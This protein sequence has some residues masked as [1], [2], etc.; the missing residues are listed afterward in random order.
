MT[1]TGIDGNISYAH[2]F[3][4][5]SRL[6]LSTVV[7]WL[8]SR[9]E[10]AVLNDPSHYKRLDRVVGD[11][12][13]RALANVSFETERFDISLTGQYIGKQTIGVWNLQNYEQDRAPTN[14]DAYPV[15]YYPDLF[16]ADIQVGVK[17]NEKFRLY[18]GVDNVTDQ[19]PPYGATGTGTGTAIFP[20]TG[21]Y[22]YAG[23]R[24][25]M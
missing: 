1:T 21:R 15:V 20:V 11:P 9:R 16:I 24:L 12:Q 6:N 3:D 2:R 19:L 22:F 18:A 17:V 8:E 5:G 14:A 25:K 4:N 13:W 10:Y 7:S 23:A